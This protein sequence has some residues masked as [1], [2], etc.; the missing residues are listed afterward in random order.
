MSLVPGSPPVVLADAHVHIYDCFRVG[1][2]FD[3]AARNFR[4]EARRRGFEDHFQ[5]VLLLT[6][7][8]GDQWFH[9]IAATGD[10]SPSDGSGWTVVPTQPRGSR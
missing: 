9:A 10:V 2:F 3:S 4:A 5:G 7:S 8:V 1:R 6:E